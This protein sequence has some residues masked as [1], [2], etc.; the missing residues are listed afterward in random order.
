MMKQS[1]LSHI[2]KH[3][4]FDTFGTGINYV[5]MFI[6]S[7]II[8]R[9]IGAELFGKYSLSNSIFLILGVFAVFGLNTGVVR[10]TSKYNARRDFQASKGTLLSGMMLSGGFGLVLML[11]VIALS[12][13]IATKVF[14][15]VEGISWVLRIHMIALPFYA[16]MLV[17]DGYTQGFKSL[18]Y[19]VTVEFLT[20]PVVR[21]V[22]VIVL[23]AIGLRLRGV[24]YATVISYVLAALLGLYFAIRISQFD[25][26]RTKARLVTNELFLYSLPLVLAR[27]M[28]VIIARSN[29]IL[30]GYFKESTS[31]GLFGAAVT[32][33]AF[34]SIS[35]NSFARIFAPIASDLWEKQRLGELSETFKAVTKWVFSIGLPIFLIFELFS[36][37]LLRVFGAEF[38]RA[39]TTL[40]FL[41]AGQIVNALVGP[42]GYVLTMT[43]RQKLNLVNSIILA[44][45][46]VSLNIVMI[47]RWGINGAG[48]AT[49][50]SLALINIVRVIEVKI[51]YGFTPFRSDIYKPVL[52]G[53]ITAASIYFLNMYLGLMSLKGTLLLCIAFLCIYLGLLYMLGLKEEKQVVLRILRRGK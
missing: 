15:N 49:A 12:P 7:V 19:S 10:L 34:I 14:K 29:T 20:R 53:C 41:A 26:F 32:V 33:A 37:I 46:N 2:V 3:A 51:I 6:S 35:L 28:N 1:T 48:L 43:G 5:L 50:L 39:G 36:P 27:F 25:F 17:A 4:G 38:A 8:T 30:V 24:L 16:L 11:I 47:P 18:K 44:G 9:T 45:V 21:L 42:V 23:F 40:R 52:A 22:L 31:T 13:Q